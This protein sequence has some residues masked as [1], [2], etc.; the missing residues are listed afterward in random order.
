[1]HRE[2]AP[3]WH[4]LGHP[5]THTWTFTALQK[6]SSATSKVIWRLAKIFR[7]TSSRCSFYTTTHWDNNLEKWKSKCTSLLTRLPCIL[8]ATAVKITISTKGRRYEKV[9]AL[10]HLFS[11]KTEPG[12]KKWL[13]RG[14]KTASKGSLRGL[15]KSPQ[16][17]LFCWL[18]LDKWLWNLERRPPT[19]C[20]IFSIIWS[21]LSNKVF[22][23]RTK[24]LMKVCKELHRTTSP[25]SPI[26][27]T[28]L[29]GKKKLS[30]AW[31]L[32]SSQKQCC[33]WAA[34]LVTTSWS[35]FVVVFVAQFNYLE[36]G[37]IF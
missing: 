20:L 31:E 36:A 10:P 24:R 2:L 33:C 14:L 32:K 1:M 13:Q 8:S 30:K 16:S 3:N 19:L 35:C 6:S 18:L 9:E 28:A 17:G 34:F 5:P 15:W 25:R 29:V 26:N 37:L 11:R 22:S 27:T 7:H 23:C 4:L 12:L 21:W